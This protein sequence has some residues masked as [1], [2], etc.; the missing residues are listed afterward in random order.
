MK[1]V[2]KAISCI[3]LLFILTACSWQEYFIVKN[4]SN[5]AIEISYKV[6]EVKGFGIFETNPTLY[7]ATSSGDIDWGRQLTFVDSDTSK[8][9][10]KITLPAKSILKFGILDNDTYEKYNQKFINGRE[11]NL[12]ELIVINKGDTTQISAKL[13]DNFFKKE[14]GCIVYEL[15]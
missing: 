10:V 2:G 5:S 4:T 12:D 9:M 15:R 1:R 11:F 14:K 6:S 13:F 7:K 3:L 8:L